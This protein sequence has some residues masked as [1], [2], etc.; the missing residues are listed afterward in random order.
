MP[1]QDE[2]VIAAADLVT[3][4]GQA[5]RSWLSPSRAADTAVDVSGSPGAE[6]IVMSRDDSPSAEIS[7]DRVNQA[8][9]GT[10][11]AVG[12]ASLMALRT[13]RPFRQWLRKTREKSEASRRRE[14]A[15]RGP[16]RRV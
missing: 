11:L 12:L 16:H 13:H 1:G 9:L 6:R 10:P 8:Q 5:A 3:R 7:S 4:L 15:I 14:T 2:L